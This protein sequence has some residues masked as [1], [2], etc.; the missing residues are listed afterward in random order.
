M[1]YNGDIGKYRR[2]GKMMKAEW[3][4]SR[5]NGTRLNLGIVE[6]SVFWDDTVSKGTPTGYKYRYGN[7]QSNVY[8]VNIEAAKTAAL[9]SVRNRLHAALDMI[10]E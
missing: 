4:D 9:K 3:V 5:Y 1:R 7:F 8:Y 2:K 6:V 10:G